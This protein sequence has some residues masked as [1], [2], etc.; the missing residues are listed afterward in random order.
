MKKC[1]CW[2]CPDYNTCDVNNMTRGEVKALHCVKYLLDRGIPFEDI[3][4]IQIAGH[5]YEQGYRKQSELTPCDVCKF[6][7]PSSTDGKPCSVCPAQE[8]KGGEE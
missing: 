1:K 4:K 5:L 8:M 6:N 3:V 2:R 7:P